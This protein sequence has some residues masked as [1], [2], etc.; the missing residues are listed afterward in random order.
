MQ[1]GIW[2]VSLF[3]AAD[4]V[5]WRA[6]FIFLSKQI[7][8][9]LHMNLSIKYRKHVPY[10]GKIF[11]LQLRNFRENIGVKLSL[12]DSLLRVKIRLI[13]QRFGKFNGCH[14]VLYSWKTKYLKVWKFDI[15]LQLRIIRKT[16]MVF[17]RFD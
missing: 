14:L 8:W 1:P 17:Q 12:R 5:V 9:D 15:I 10:Y 6:K 7:S 11:I 13:N 16:F 2:T 3:Q 4:R